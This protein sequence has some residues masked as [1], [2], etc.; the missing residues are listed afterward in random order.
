[1]YIYAVLDIAFEKLDVTYHEVDGGS[2]SQDVGTRNDSSASIEPF[3]GSRVV[4][5]GSLAVQLHVT[6]VNTR[7]EDPWI[8]QVGLSSL[9]QEDLEIMIQ[10]RQ[11]SSNDTPTTSPTTYDD[12]NLSW[13]MTEC[14]DL[15]GLNTSSG[16]VILI[17]VP[18]YD[19]YRFGI[20]Q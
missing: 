3:R 6:W 16:I 8:V 15:K 14:V 1:M 11:S 17:C 9:N 20:D 10:V 19:F 4:K 2:T 12:I 5:R 13:S 18:T 7:A